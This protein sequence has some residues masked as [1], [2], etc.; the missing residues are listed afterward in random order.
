MQPLGYATVAPTLLRL[1]RG[2]YRYRLLS[3]GIERSEVGYSTA[4]TVVG[5]SWWAPR[6]RRI[7]FYWHAAHTLDYRAI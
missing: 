4:H 2:L 1:S 6:V 7:A 3:L 5:A